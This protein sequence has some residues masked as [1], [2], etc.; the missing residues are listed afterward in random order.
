MENLSKKIYGYIYIYTYIYI[1]IESVILLLGKNGHRI[2]NLKDI[3][4]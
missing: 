3:Y 1:Y 2:K 4:I